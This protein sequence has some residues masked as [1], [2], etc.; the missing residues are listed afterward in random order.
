MR[1]HACCEAVALVAHDALALLLHAA[2]HMRALLG[3][4]SDNDIIRMPSP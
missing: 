3:S 1:Q 4:S 2:L